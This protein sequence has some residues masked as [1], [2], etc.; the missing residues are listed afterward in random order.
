MYS[1]EIRS[2]ANTSLFEST[3]ISNLVVAMSS[4]SPYGFD[5]VFSNPTQF[6]EDMLFHIRLIVRVTRIVLREFGALVDT[7]EVVFA[8]NHTGWEDAWS[9]VHYLECNDCLPLL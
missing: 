7:D 8:L 2:C 1:A 4:S 3:T 5:V 9:A 6:C